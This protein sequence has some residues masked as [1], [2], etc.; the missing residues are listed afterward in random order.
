[1]SLFSELRTPAPIIAAA[2]ASG[3]TLLSSTDARAICE[4]YGIPVPGD[5]LASS[6]DDAARLAGSFGYPVV[7]KIASQDIA[8][9][10]DAGSVLL[11]LADDAAVRAGYGTVIANAQPTRTHRIDGVQSQMAGAR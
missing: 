6:A 7:L 1:M 11:A 2:R 8:H 10:S 3:R 5:G 9:K 4:A